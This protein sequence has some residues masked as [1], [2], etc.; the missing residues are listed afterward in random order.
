[1]SVIVR[2]LK[3]VWEADAEVI[4]LLVGII[5][6]FYCSAVFL[7]QSE[8]FSI[9]IYPKVT[10]VSVLLFLIA[11]F[12]VSSCFVLLFVRPNKPISYMAEKT[13]G[14]V[15][16]VGWLRAAILMI[17]F[18][19]FFSAFSSFKSLIP[20][21]HPYQVDPDLHKLDIILHG[22]KL[23]WV[24]FQPF[25]EAVEGSLVINV[26][27][28]FWFILVVNVLFWFV[29][30]GRDP[31]LRKRYLLS[32]LLCWF[33]NGA[34]LAVLFSSAGPAFFAKLYPTLEDPYRS[35]LDYLRT[36][37]GGEAVWALGIQEHLWNLYKAGGAGV[38][39]GISAMPSMHVSMAWLIF[40]LACQVRRWLAAVAFIY[41][42]LIMLGSVHLAWH[43]LSDG[44]VAIIMTSLVWFLVGVW[45]R[46]KEVNHAMENASAE[47][48]TGY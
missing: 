7:G 17:L 39:S 8:H 45:C 27:Y 30:D 28:N 43:Y 22:G 24:W 32:Y 18:S 19:F 25:I 3:E 16:T 29:W 5:L 34:F 10:V 12:L 44:Y 20:L 46:K 42:L 38:G 1:M 35:L 4:S 14:I 13:I 6:L 37:N 36:A 23:P 15:R 21:I 33:F 48:A 31:F 26:F 11:L 40:L 41:V 47:S 9:L 2:S